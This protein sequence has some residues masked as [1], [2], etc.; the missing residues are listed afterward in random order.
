MYRKLKETQSI[1]SITGHLPDSLDNQGGF[2]QLYKVD[3]IKKLTPQEDRNYTFLR[4][5]IVIESCKLF[6][7]SSL[8]LIPH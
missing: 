3:P 6:I 1:D 2:Y 8:P 4:K 7:L 5:C